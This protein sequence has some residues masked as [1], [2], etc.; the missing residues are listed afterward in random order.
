[1]LDVESVPATDWFE[2][3]LKDLLKREADQ[4]HMPVHQACKAIV[5]QIFK[6]LLNT[7]SESEKAGEE[8][9]DTSKALLA[10]SLLANCLPEVVMPHAQSLPP[11]LNQP[12]RLGSDQKVVSLTANILTIVVPLMKNP[13]DLFLAQIEESCVALFIKQGVNIQVRYFFC[14]FIKIPFRGQVLEN[15]Y[16]KPLPLVIYGKELKNASAFFI[17]TG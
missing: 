7:D 6:Q 9:L 16:W 1:M 11:Y 15:E 12:L 8:A 13:P 10:L 14:F 2:R 5:D 17:S 4:K 3:M